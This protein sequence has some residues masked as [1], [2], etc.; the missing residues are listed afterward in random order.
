MQ[1]VPGLRDGGPPAPFHLVYAKTNTAVQRSAPFCGTAPAS[2]RV[3]LELPSLRDEPA[4]GVL[5][6]LAALRSRTRV[7]KLWGGGRGRD[8]ERGGGHRRGRHDLRAGPASSALLRDVR[9]SGVGDDLI[10]DALCVFTRHT[11]PL[12]RAM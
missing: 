2:G 4:A 8:R 9:D 11:C 3:V 7:R 12:S 5:D 10:T 6:E 1:A